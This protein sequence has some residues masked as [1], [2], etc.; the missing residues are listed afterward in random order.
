MIHFLPP[1]NPKMVAKVPAIAPTVDVLLGQPRGRRPGERQ[2]SRPRRPDRDRQGLGPPRHPALDAGQLARLAVGAR[3][4]HGRG[5]RDR[6]PP[7]RDHDPEGRGA[8]GHP[9]RR[10]AARP[11]RG[12][13]PASSRPIL[14]HA[15]L[16]TARGVAN[17]EAICAASPRMQGLS[18]GPGR[19][20]RQPA[21][22]DDPRR[23]R[24]SRLPRAP[25][26]RP[27]TTP[28]RP[29]PTYQQDLWHYT[30]ARMVDACVTYGVLPYY[31]PFG[32]IA[33]TVACEDQFRNAY[34][35]G[36][37]GA[38]SLHPAQIDI[39]KRVFSPDPADVAHARRVID[40]DGRRHRSDHARRQD[41]GRRLGEAVPRDRRPR[42]A[43]R[44]PRP[45]ARRAVRVGRVPMDRRSFGR[46][47]R[48]CTCRRPT[49]GRWRR[50]RRSRATR[51]SSTS[52]TLS[53]PTPR[54]SLVN[55]PSPPS[56][57]GDY[58]SRELTIRCNGLA[59][60]WGSD[61]LAAA[62]GAAPSAVVI[63]KVDSVAYARRRRQP[64]STPPARRGTSI[65]AM[66]ETPTAIFDVRAIAAHP[67]VAVLVMGTNDLAKELRAPLRRRAVEPRRRYLATGGARR[68]RGGQGRSSTASTTT[69]RTPTGSRPSAARASRWAST[70]RR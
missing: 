49:S 66:V 6:R 33:D 41:G 63:P 13:R 46:A 51:S 57:S 9:L 7:R 45:R 58:G 18:L 29:A 60:P 36:C 5:D 54:R 20:R 14:V 22:E 52:R 10:P 59:T 31:G 16:E 8:R 40:G 24:P 50:P 37:V 30:I 70:A 23:W 48:S 61:D 53:R 67:R 38:W 69:S 27:P 19:P 15:I 32:D 34:L 28:R 47:G 44:R 25:G 65:W 11:A 68:P 64:R 56:T 2:G 21:D 55:R 26:S 42:R 62:G 39:A 35:L 43:A 17:V 12:A 1:S 3:R 4:P